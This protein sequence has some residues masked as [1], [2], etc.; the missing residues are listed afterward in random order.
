M[1]DEVKR[2]KNHNAGTNFV[3]QN[4]L[5]QSQS[6]LGCLECLGQLVLEV[7]RWVWCLFLSEAVS[8]TVDPKLWFEGLQV[9][10]SA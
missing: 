5:Q 7:K 4:I 2:E 9:S 3:F 6:V 8:A 1:Q 10:I